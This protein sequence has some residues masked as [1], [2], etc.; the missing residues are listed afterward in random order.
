MSDHLTLPVTHSFMM[1]NPLVMRQVRAF[2]ADGQ[3][4]QDLTM[5]GVM[6]GLQ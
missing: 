2:L 6:F 5:S 3:F 4:D 1:N